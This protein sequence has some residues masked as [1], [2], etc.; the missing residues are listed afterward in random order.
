MDKIKEIRIIR[1]A[2]P[3]KHPY[4]LSFADIY[5]FQSLFVVIETDEGI[6]IGE[7]TPLPGY[8]KESIQSV[9]RFSL[10][11][12]SKLLGMDIH[13][14]R[15]IIIKMRGKEYFAASGFLT[16]L[17]ILNGELSMPVEEV[18]IPL[19]HH[20]DLWDE[21]LVKK[22]IENALKK[23]QLFFKV[24]I[25]RDIL[26]EAWI[27]NQLASFIPEDA[28]IVCDANKSLDWDTA[29]KFINAIV[30]REKI[31]Y[32]EQPFPESYYRQ[33]SQFQRKTGIP[34]LL[35]ESIYNIED[36]EQMIIEG[37]CDYIKLKLM[38]HGGIK[39]VVDMVKRA[40]EKSVQVVLGNGVQ[41][42]LGCY[43]EAL[44]HWGIKLNT[45]GEMVGF[46]KQ[47]TLL[48][49]GLLRTING[50]LIISDEMDLGRIVVKLM[51]KGGE[52]DVIK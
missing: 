22:E 43:V 44:I 1:I 50:N 2:I 31:A 6:G 41:S 47:K 23:G 10:I 9:K 12:A 48:F 16:A 7:V 28:R 15:K 4:R 45:P 37:G 49:N 20:I 8:N 38:K 46:I 29:Q 13:E 30:K 24:K 42:E 27:L 18:S 51:E 40:R 34:V 33:S 39:E 26:K 25:G 21:W 14:A 17:D 36:I 5:E 11:W 19:I 52:I 3:L 35:D 32:I